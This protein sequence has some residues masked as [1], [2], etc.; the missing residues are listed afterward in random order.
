M[1]QAVRVRVVVAPDKFKGTLPAA[2]A[3]SA[4]EAGLL[5]AAAA[6]DLEVAVV[7]RPVA[8]GGEGTLEA[9]LAAGFEQVR[10][11]A[12]GPT[13]VPGEAA[14]GRRGDE[15][16]VELAGICGMPRLPGGRLAP[17]D[18]TTLGLGVAAARAVEAGCRRLVLAIGG[19]ASTDGG[20]GLLA[21]L[22]AQLLDEEGQPVPPT[23]RHLERI[24]RFEPAGLDAGPGGGLHV[25]GAPVELVVACD[26]TNPLL[27]PAGA[28][29][30]FGPQ[31]G[32]SP[33]VVTT[34][35]A[36][37]AHWVEV[38]GAAVGPARARAAAER[39]GAGAAGGVGFAA[40][41]VL[42]AR[43]VPGID[44]VLDL[45]GLDGALE[46]ADLVV[47]GEGSL[48]DQTRAGK[49]VAGV[50][51]L[52]AARGIPVA[53]V[54]GR[55]EVD[56]AELAALGIAR[57]VGLTDLAPSGAAALAEPG[58]WLREAGRVLLAGWV[59]G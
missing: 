48:D 42:G 3:A 10:V 18:A 9:A 15:A 24:A 56:P 21:G 51:R 38:V 29:A 22:G 2:A 50:A 58:R 47:V 27:G 23:G 7:C 52:A 46:G 13:G 25:G 16:L 35:E 32:A 5:D 40:M 43:P 4:I 1:R 53:A 8:D 28:A 49:A 57:A 19:S 54:A 33:A 20:A 44:L 17:L 34:L 59:A 45:V 31:K 6:M 14:Y 36:G 26:V 37:L 39:P 41:A 11:A 12:P 30:V 55:V